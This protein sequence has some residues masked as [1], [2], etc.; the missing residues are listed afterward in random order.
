MLSS[1]SKRYKTKH[2]SFHDEYIPAKILEKLCQNLIERNLTN[3][4]FK[5]YV[6]F[7]EEFLKKNSFKM[8]YKAGFRNLYWGL[9]SGSQRVLNLMNKGTNI[10]AVEK[11]LKRS[12]EAKI[13]NSCF[14]IFGFPGETFNDFKKTINFLEKNRKNIHLI[15]TS[16]FM[17]SGNSTIGLNPSKWN[18]KII[19][20][21]E[22]T[23]NLTFKYR[24]T[25]LQIRKI[26]EASFLL[27]F[28]I[29]DLSSNFY[30]CMMLKTISRT[31]MFALS[32]L[33]IKPK[34]EVYKLLDSNEF[35]A[36]Y[37][38]V[39][40]AIIKQDKKQF[41]QM[42]DFTKSSYLNSKMNSKMPINDLEVYIF[43]KIVNMNMN[44]KELISAIM[45]DRDLSLKS[46]RQAVVNFYK[47][48][49]KNNAI[50]FYTNTS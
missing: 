25:P 9:E 46:S 34:K 2:F 50:L 35:D 39:L 49:L 15:M 22:F 42:A 33:N 10:V 3:F 11:I 45:G 8:M 31:L 27:N 32:T 12:A 48:L 4:R 23:D 20:K 17:L 28:G 36:L 6:R 38:I 30:K 29:C 43:N 37:P 44:N 24:K 19:E 26:N 40:G 18:L 13:K 47:K 7:E 14:I 16:A 1:L 21:D 41:L 5:G